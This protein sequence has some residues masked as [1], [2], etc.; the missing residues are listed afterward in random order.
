MYL[1][2]RIIMLTFSQLLDPW[3][4]IF[5]YF[6]Y[7]LAII[8]SH[9]HLLCSVSSKITKFI[10]VRLT[11]I[12]QLLDAFFCCF[13][14]STLFSPCA[15]VLVIFI[16]LFSCS[17]IISSSLSRLLIGYIKEF[18]TSDIMVFKKNSKSF[19]LTFSYSFHLSAEY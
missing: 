11:H 17:F 3:F 9:N 10:Y 8:F 5:H 13:P 14:F 2:F 18:F 19:Y 12:P 6:W 4:D 7:I 16:D 15:S 1:F